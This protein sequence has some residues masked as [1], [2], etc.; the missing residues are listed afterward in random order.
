MSGSDLFTGTLNILILRTLRENPL[1]GYAIGRGI[2]N[3]SR[4]VLD[5]D[6]GALY[7]ALHRLERQGFLSSEWG[8]TETNRRAKF[9]TL[10]RAGAK[11][12]EVESERWSDF[13]E[14][15]QAVLG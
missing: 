8:R 6:E 13:S 14:A 4:G 5:V 7:P 9:Y 15:V 2:R 10:T 1:H 11:H 3:T 12:L